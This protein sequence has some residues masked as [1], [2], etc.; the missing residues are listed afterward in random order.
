MNNITYYKYKT[1]IWED[2][3][4]SEVNTSLWIYQNNFMEQIKKALVQSIYSVL[5][6]F[7]SYKAK[8]LRK[9]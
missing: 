9:D 3:C 8:V 1:T 7:Y 5:L 4:F 6:H 2:D